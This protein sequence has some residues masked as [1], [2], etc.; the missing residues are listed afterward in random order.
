MIF[1]FIE[2]WLI[3]FNKSGCG[4]IGICVCLRG[5]WFCFVSLSFVICI[6]KILKYLGVK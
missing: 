5:V 3:V 1:N 6:F 2:V 4:G